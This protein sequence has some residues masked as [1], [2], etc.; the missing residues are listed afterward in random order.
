MTI[1]ELIDE[2]KR[3]LSTSR[4]DSM[5]FAEYVDNDLYEHWKR[6]ALMFVQSAYPNNPQVSTMELYVA[7]NDSTQHCITILSI[8]EAF[9]AVDPKEIRVDYDGI[10][11]TIFN[12]FATCA[13]QLLRRQQRV[14]VLA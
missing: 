8:L 9:K 12:N 4:P 14:L 1:D 11:D 7:K 6:K 5:G 3:V 13:R 10:L 2:G